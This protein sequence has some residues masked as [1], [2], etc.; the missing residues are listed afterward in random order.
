MKTRK[1]GLLLIMVTLLT[2][3]M[4]I[5]CSNSRKSG[6]GESEKALTAA[7]GKNKAPEAA[8]TRETGKMPNPVIMETSMGTIKIQ[9]DWEKAPITCENFARYVNEKFYDGTI[10]HRVIPTFVIQGGGF[11]ADGKRK[12]T[13]EPIKN[14]AGN[15][16]RNLRGTICMARTS[17]VNSATSQFFINVKDNPPLDHRDES[18]RGY[19]Y[20]VFGKVIEGMDVVDKIKAVPTGN[21]PMGMRDWPKEPVVIK[22]CY[23]P[24]Q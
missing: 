1:L 17:V 3:V 7:S 24:E 4:L 16:L 19:G 15:G 2:S 11:T 5:S 20:A 9:L 6:T 13:H 23:F 21:G 10:F 14:E 18:V 12:E 8:A 22:R